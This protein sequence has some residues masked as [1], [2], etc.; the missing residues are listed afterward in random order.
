MNYI[1]SKKI[2][3]LFLFFSTIFSLLIPLNSFGYNYSLSK[4]LMYSN[5]GVLVDKQLNTFAFNAKG[6]KKLSK[7]GTLLHNYVSNETGDILSMDVDPL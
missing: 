4:I 7:D 1:S 2:T 6:F 5:I 3:T